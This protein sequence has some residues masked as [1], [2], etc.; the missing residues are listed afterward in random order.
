MRVVHH[1]SNDQSQWRVY[2]LLPGQSVTISAPNDSSGDVGGV[3][4]FPTSS[5]HHPHQTNGDA[6]LLYIAVYAPNSPEAGSEL[7]G[8]YTV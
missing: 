8:N 1:S 6:V 7:Y 3:Q 2:T 5:W 4:L